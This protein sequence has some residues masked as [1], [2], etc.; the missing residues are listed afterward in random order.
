MPARALPR[1]DPRAAL[2]VSPVDVR[3]A[4]WCTARLRPGCRAAAPA[5]DRDRRRWKPARDRRL[6]RAGRPELLGHAR[7]DRRPLVNGVD[8]RLDSTSFIRHNLRK[9]FPDHWSFML[10]EVALYSFML[11]LLTGTSSALFFVASPT[12]RCIEDRT[13]PC[14]GRKSRRRTSR[15]C[16]SPRGARR[17]RDAPDPPLGSARV[18]GVDDRA[19]GSCLLHRRVPQTPRARWIIGVTLLV[20]GIGA[21]FTGYSLPDDLLSG[22][23]LRIIYSAVLSIPLVGRGRVSSSSAASSPRPNAVSAVHPAHAADPARDHRAALGAHLALVWHQT[24]TQFRP[25]AQPKTR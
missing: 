18:R 6:H 1:R 16:G 21:G 2:P 12:G 25:G 17:P 8:D 19:P 10:G 3:C 24:H 13:H 14:R 5:A 20:A 4:R 7:R 11:L 9:V 23:G 22:T 15:S